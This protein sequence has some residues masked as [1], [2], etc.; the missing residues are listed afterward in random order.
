MRMTAQSRLLF[1]LLALAFACDP[2]NAPLEQPQV[3]PERSPFEYP[4]HLWDN[5]VT[6]ETVLHVHV[7]RE[8]EVDSVDVFNG[9]GHADFDSSAVR[10][11]RKLHFV[12]GRRG[13]RPVDMWTKLPVRFELD[14]AR[15]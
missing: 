4:I 7:T 11:A 1:V 15:T 8:G 14:S 9:S 10:G 12:P 6:G 5:R 2:A 13:K 3:I